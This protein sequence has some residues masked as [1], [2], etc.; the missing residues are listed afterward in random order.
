MECES[1]HQCFDGIPSTPKYLENGSWKSLP[2]PASAVAYISNSPFSCR[3]LLSDLTACEWGRR[4][5]GF[6]ISHRFSQF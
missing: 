3:E 5:D 4:P 1:G 6:L 2:S